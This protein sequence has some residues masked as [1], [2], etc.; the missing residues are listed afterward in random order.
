MNVGKVIMVMVCMIEMGNV[1]EVDQHS[2]GYEGHLY[3]NS[4]R[5]H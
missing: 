5:V 3:E 2:R 4:G 1:L